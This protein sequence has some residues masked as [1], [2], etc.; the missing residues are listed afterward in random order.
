MSIIHSVILGIVEGITEFLPI[1][2]TGHLILS[3]HLL[4]I[5]QDNF[6]KSFEI[7]IQ[8]GAILSVVWLYRK[9]IFPFN[10]LLWKK[11]LTAFLPTA[12]IG[13]LL[14][15]FI[16]GYL[17]GNIMVVAVALIIGGAIIILFEKLFSSHVI[18]QDNEANVES[19]FPSN[20]ILNLSYKKALFIGLIQSLSVIPGVSR[21]AATIIGGQ[22]L[23]LTRKAIV[24][25]SF[26]LA[27]PTMFAASGYD[28]SKSSVDFTSQQLLVLF[29]GFVVSFFIALIAVKWLLRFIKNHDFTFFGVYRIIIGLIFI[30]LFF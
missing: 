18:K 25:F 30:F 17:L 16:K 8:L 26:L 13:F 3:S 22:T 1:S 15:Q 6:T 20:E 27:I 7:I 28:F 24:E 14:Y 4:G 10:L 21:A 9:T 2:S 23:G 5:V 12:I 11:V 19:Y 29:V